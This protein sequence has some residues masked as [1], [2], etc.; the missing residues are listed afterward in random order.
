M[1]A[2]HRTSNL[3]GG[4]L[5][6]CAAFLMAC[7]AAYADDRILGDWDV[8]VHMGEMKVPAQLELRKN[9][10]GGLTGTIS[11][12]QG[13]MEIVDIKVEGDDLFFTQKLVQDEAELLFNFVG[14]I[15]GDTFSG[16]LT[17]ELGEMKVTGKRPPPPSLV[18]K[19]K[20]T[21]DS[22]LGVLERTLEITED[23][24][25][26]YITEEE[27]YEV[28]DIVLKGNAVSFEVTVNAA[29]QPIDLVFEGIIRRDEMSGEFLAEGSPVAVVTAKREKPEKKEKP[30][31]AAP[32]DKPK[33]KKKSK[34]SKTSTSD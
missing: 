14:K 18:G 29:G 22:Q 12:A 1:I 19:W 5:C 32:S 25:G 9:D 6:L 3:S 26:K 27:A 31:K 20:V 17:S 8:T 13:T 21:S 24:K 4:A 34:E 2:I 30:E 11:G 15:E 23:M 33:D 16:T 7:T 28:T 10:E